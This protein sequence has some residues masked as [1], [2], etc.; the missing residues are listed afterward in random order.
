MT[1]AAGI[2]MKPV[3]ADSSP[4]PKHSVTA[5]RISR[6]LSGPRSGIWPKQTAVTGSVRTS[7]LKLTDRQ[8]RI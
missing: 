5:Q 8:P 4:K 1:A 3:R 6:L 7:A 2:Q